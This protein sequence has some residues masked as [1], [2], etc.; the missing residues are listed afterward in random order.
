M[1]TVWLG[2]L[3]IVG[4]VFDS[5]SPPRMRVTVVDDGRVATQGVVVEGEGDGPEAHVGGG[6]CSPSPSSDVHTVPFG[7]HKRAE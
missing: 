1:A 5:V 6:H 4:G 2:M 7:R 3:L